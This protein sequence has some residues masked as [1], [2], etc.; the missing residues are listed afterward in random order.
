MGN[1]NVLPSHTAI[2]RTS[3][4]FNTIDSSFSNYRYNTFFDDYL[5]PFLFGFF[6]NQPFRTRSRCWNSSRILHR[7]EQPVTPRIAAKSVLET[8][9]EPVSNRTPKMANTGQQRIPQK[10]SAFMTMGWKTPIIR[11]VATAI[12]IPWKCTIIIYFIPGVR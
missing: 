6:G 7:Q 2:S 5:S 3:K 8:K 9:R 1:G 10:Y 12:I 11:K 4:T